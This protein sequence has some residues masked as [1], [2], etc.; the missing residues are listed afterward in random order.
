MS[1]T[2]P[3]DGGL[4]AATALRS[5]TMNTAPR[6]VIDIARIIDRETGLKELIAACEEMLDA[7]PKYPHHIGS[8]GSTAHLIQERQNA[9]IDALRAALSKK[10]PNQRGA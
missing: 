4:R 6:S 2:T 3:S 10:S 5:Y 1:D 7:H 9:A 8:E